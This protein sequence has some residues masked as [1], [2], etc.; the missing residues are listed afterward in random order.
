MLTDDQIREKAIAHMQRFGA[1]LTLSRAVILTEPD[2]HFYKAIRPLSSRSTNLVSPFV[3]LR[4]DGR[5]VSVSAGDVMPGIVTKLY[6]WAAMRAD[7]VL[8][9]AVIDPDFSVPRHVEVWSAIIRELMSGK[10]ANQ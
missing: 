7:P 5:I 2:G 10:E 3:V 1:D 9:K 4:A 8:Q 6:G